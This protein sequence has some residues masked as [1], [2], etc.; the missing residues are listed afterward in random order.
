MP[1]TLSHPAAILPFRGTRLDFAALVIGSMMPDI[2]YFL[3]LTDGFNVFAHYSPAGWLV[4][5]AIGLPFWLV[6]QWTRRPL[7]E[8]LP[9]PHREALRALPPRRFSRWVIPSL[10]L[11]ALTHVFW[12]G[13]TH[14]QGFMPR[15]FPVM[16]EQVFGM[17]GYK[18]LQHGGTLAGAGILALFY[19]RWLRRQPERPAGGS[20]R[21]VLAVAGAA[22][23]LATPLAVR[24]AAH[25]EGEHPYA[26][27]LAGRMA[28]YGISAFVP[29]YAAA[30]LAARAIRS[31]RHSLNRP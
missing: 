6:Y 18:W 3:R 20:W 2:G 1:F 22:L 9:S 24:F 5:A 16:R 8:L 17:A 10:L 27:V 13:F 14:L 26:H 30:A 28:V 11:G 12:D 19:M 29:L 15:W 31:N 7:T 4:A 23:A 25:Y 21:P